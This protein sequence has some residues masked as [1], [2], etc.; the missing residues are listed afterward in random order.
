MKLLEDIK[1]L[2]SNALF[3]GV[4]LFLMAIAVCH[5]LS[6]TWAARQDYAF[7]YIVPI[8][9][10]Y[11]LYDR[12]P[13]ISGYLLG[14]SRDTVDLGSWKNSKPVGVAYSF[15]FGS[16]LFC[17]LLTFL[18]F[19]VFYL[20]TKNKGAPAF[21]FTFAFSFTFFA[22]AYWVSGSDALGN[23]K[24][25]SQRLGF[26]KL[27][28]FPAFIWILAAPMA[29]KV[30]EIISLWLLSIVADIS[31]GV[32]D[33]LGYMV[34]LRGNVIEFP[35]GSIGVADA[36]SG[37]RSLMACLF[38]GSFLS[39]AMLDKFWKK[40]LLVAMA[41]VFAFLNNLIRALFLAF[42][43]YE[44]GPDAISG[45]VHD[46]AGYLILG[47][48]VVEL[49]VLV[50]I[51]NINPIPKEFRDTSKNSDSDGAEALPDDGN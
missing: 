20:L 7:G 37:I 48:T 34:T 16:M 38:A 28:I 3:F 22:M 2:P 32:M 25:P 13:K 1:K 19:A 31:Y 4:A 23:K 14:N 43:A 18:F 51:F 40:F 5:V 42:W 47:M 6:F 50:S 24:S 9:V 11:I 35:K 39:A 27:F 46:T 8:F 36:C 29:S 12:W 45:A 33:G 15:L 26:T 49:L 30:E 44:N 17:G 21:G 10:L 41:M